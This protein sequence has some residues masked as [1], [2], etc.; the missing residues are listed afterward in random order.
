M[1]PDQGNIAN[2]LGVVMRVPG[3]F[4]MNFGYLWIKSGKNKELHRHQSSL[5]EPS[6]ICDSP[7]CA[8]S[9]HQMLAIP[10]PYLDFL[11]WA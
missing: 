8:L 6:Q 3:A 5:I 4:V 11:W 2:S 9:R 10:G 1:A 7:R